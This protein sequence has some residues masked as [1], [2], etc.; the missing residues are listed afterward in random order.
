MR[1][2][3]GVCG[4]GYGHSSRSKVII[5]YLISKGHQVL[6]ITYGQA[7]PILR[8]FPS[9]KVNGLSISFQ[10][11]RLSFGKTII[12]NASN[13]LSNLKN[14]HSIKRKIDAFYPDVCITDME[15]LVPIIAYWRNLP[16]I[17][18]D[19][20]HRLTHLSLKVPNQYKK[21]YFLAK[22]FVNRCVSDAN[23][24]IILSFTKEKPSGKKAYLV[25]P[26]LRKEVVNLKTVKGTHILVYQ[27]KPN[28][29][30]LKTL[31]LIP[32][33][34]IIYGHN[35]EKKDAN[36]F[37]K[38]TGHGM[39]KNLSSCKAVIA[40]AGFT[41]ISESLHLKKPY[42]AVPLQ[43]QFEQTLNAL[44]LKKSGYG[45]FSE[46]PSLSDLQKFL[47]NIPQYKKALKSYKSN[48]EE[49]IHALDKVLKNL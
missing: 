42:F 15:P 9:I 8:H 36:L 24:F 6:V 1:I 47:F 41:L 21:D 35:K 49:A 37:F 29:A 44:F 23:A 7:Y 39:L 12:D 43:G 40:T 3:Y 18:I 46:N 25:S 31:R 28:N 32:E 5:Q 34:F 26:I 10:N 48:P 33:K 14:W 38:K 17:S 2:L 20:Q 13:M 30:L 19:N 16:L 11:N 22:A 27:T 45:A 4:E